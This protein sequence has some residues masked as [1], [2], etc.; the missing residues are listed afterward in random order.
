MKYTA[1]IEVANE[2]GELYMILPDDLIKELEWEIGDTL[3]WN[4]EGD[5]IILTRKE[6]EKND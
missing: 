1:T 5:T 3:N 4:I 2:D 6:V